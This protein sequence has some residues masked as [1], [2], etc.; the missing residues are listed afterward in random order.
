[1]RGEKKQADG[2]GVFAGR[3]RML[4]QRGKKRERERG[5]EKDFLFLLNFFSNSFFKHSNFNQTK[6]H[7]FES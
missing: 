3:K 7:A 4:G 6:I 5:R 1:V 2:L